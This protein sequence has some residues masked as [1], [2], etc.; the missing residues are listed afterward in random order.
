[1]TPERRMIMVLGGIGDWDFLPDFREDRLCYAGKDVLYLMS[2]S[3]WSHDAVVVL[4]SW[5]G[6]PPPD[7]DA[8]AVEETTISFTDGRAYLTMMGVPIEGDVLPLPGPGTYRV[9]VAA[10]GRAELVRRHAEVSPPLWLT[11]VERFRVSFWL[12]PMFRN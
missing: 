1:M 11:G 2:E 10:S 9:R 4:E 5:T 6:E 7:T 8:E 3:Q 12:D